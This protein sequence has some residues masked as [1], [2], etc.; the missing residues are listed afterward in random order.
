MADD[1]G[2]PAFDLEVPD[3]GYA[4]WYVDAFSDDRRYGITLIAFVGSVFSP[5]Y[6]RARRRMPAAAGDHC[7]LNVALY[8]DGV[9]RWAMTERGAAQVRRRRERFAVGASELA[10]LDGA[11]LVRVDETAVP[12]P[13]PVTG[14]VTVRPR[15]L[16]GETYTLDPAGRHRWRPLATD[17]RVRV[18]F[19][20]PAVV[21]EGPGYLDT[22][23]GDEPLERAF[24]RWD[25]SRAHADGVSRVYY[26]VLRRDGSSAGLA[27]EF[28]AGGAASPVTPPPTVALPRSRWGVARGV[29]SEKGVPATLR[30]LEDT[31]FYTRSLLAASIDGRPA[32]AVHESLSLERFRTRWVRALLPFRMPR[33]AWTR[34]LTD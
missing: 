10:W 30:R 22:N 31:P 19:E 3:D 11:L 7:A 16:H 9:R 17:C 25:W 32:T 6:A 28:E 23:A 33:I 15:A 2:F 8:G 13:R 4:W 14:T 34:R 21:W 12:L 5:Y 18:A 1:G 20:R 26:D 24:R 29:R 27:L